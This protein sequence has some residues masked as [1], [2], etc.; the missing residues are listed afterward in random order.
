MINLHQVLR[1]ERYKKPLY[2]KNDSHW[3]QFGAF[4]VFQ[5]MFEKISTWFPDENFDTDFKFTE[6]ETGKGGNTGHGGDLV[7]MLMLPN[8]TETYPQLAPFKPCGAFVG[9]PYELTNVVQS[10]GRESFVRS[11]P[12]KK[13]RAIVF[14]DSFFVPLEL[15]LS[16]NFKEIIYLWKGYDRKNIEEIMTIF[17]PDIVIEEIVERHIFDSLLAEETP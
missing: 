8:L 12:T 17:K 7:K 3:N 15:F 4:L 2:F 10:P 13:L 16:E 11:C 9:F 1:P 5:N 6:D 14:R